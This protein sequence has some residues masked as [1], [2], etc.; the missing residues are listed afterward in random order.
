MRKTLSVC[1]AFVA[2][3]FSGCKKDVVLN[4]ES[5][6]KVMSTTTPYIARDVV[7]SPDGSFLLSAV[8]SIDNFNA[9]V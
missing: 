4:T 5:F 6:I 2:L 9:T 8:Q 7:E 1:F 3:T